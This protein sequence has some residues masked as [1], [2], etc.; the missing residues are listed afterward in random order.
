M[1]ATRSK[2]PVRWGNLWVTPETFRFLSNLG[3]SRIP[4]KKRQ[5]NVGRNT[6]ARRGHFSAAVPAQSRV[7]Q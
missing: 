2:E 5:S 4:R 1:K 3:S 7:R 6:A